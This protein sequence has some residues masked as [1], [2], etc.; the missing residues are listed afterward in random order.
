[1][2]ETRVGNH[3]TINL[4]TE[5]N[6]FRI[7]DGVSFHAWTFDGTVPGPVIYLNQ[8]DHVTVTLHN[9]D[10]YMMHSID[11]HAALVAPSKDFV[12]VM[13]GKSKTFSF[14]A[15]LPGV[16]M[17]HCETVPM[18]LHIAQGMYG[19]VVVTPKGGHKPNVVI[20]QSEF[21][22]SGRTVHDSICQCGTQ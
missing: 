18:A 16:F 6:F 19:M 22:E 4:T 15:E 8:G 3:V 13:P 10:P 17:Y 5:E 7:A 11:F 20:E 2:T 1:M 9:A 12:D 21:Y 14:T